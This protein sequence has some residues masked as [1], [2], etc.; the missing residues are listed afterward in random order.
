M[1]R[2]T[3]YVTQQK[4]VWVQSARVLQAD[5]EHGVCCSREV[6]D[7]HARHFDIRVSEILQTYKQ[8]LQKAP[9]LWSTM[10]TQY[11]LTFCC[12]MYLSA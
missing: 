10:T 2:K 7:R 11:M 8:L 4:D 9:V 5:V 6:L 3:K 1:A 12:Q